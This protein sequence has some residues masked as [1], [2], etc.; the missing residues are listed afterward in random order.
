MEFILSSSRLENCVQAIIELSFVWHLTII[1]EWSAHRA[2]G[3]RPMLRH[4]IWTTMGYGTASRCNEPYKRN[5]IQS[6]IKW[7]SIE[8]EHVQPFERMCTIANL[9]LI[10]NKETPK[11]ANQQQTHTRTHTPTPDSIHQP[12]PTSKLPFT[13]LPNAKRDPVELLHAVTNGWEINPRRWRPS[14][15]DWLTFWIYMQKNASSN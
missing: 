2:K 4:R 5:N 7:D 6:T 3:R 8:A 10:R 12:K 13:E 15:V 9:A 1:R 14:L 11:K